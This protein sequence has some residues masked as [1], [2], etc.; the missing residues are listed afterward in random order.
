MLRKIGFTVAA[1]IVALALVAFAP[2]LLRTDTLQYRWAGTIGEGTLTAPIGVAYTGGHL[3][4][5]DAAANRIVVF[6][7]SGSVVADWGDSAIGLARP[8]HISL[9][10]G[11]LLHVAE[12][13]SDRVTILDARGQVVRRVGGF[14]G[15]GVGELDAPGGAVALGDAVV[16]ADFYNH[17]AQA[18]TA[19]GARVIGRPGRVFRG[20]L[21]YPT[22]V[23]ADDSLVYVADAYNHRIQVF[24]SDGEY[25]RRWGGPWG[26][27]GR[28]P[29]KG[30]FNVAIGIEVSG[31]RVYVADFY[32]NRIQIFT[33][34][35]KYLGQVADSLSLPTDAAIG[36]NGDLYVVDFGHKRVVRFARLQGVSP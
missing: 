5:S 13:L 26:L 12:Y 11:G 6:D 4:V 27:G 1:V 18:F 15:S 30:W 31:G 34:R 2:V 22:D 7:T 17:R 20:R 21:H 14:T 33:D 28:G 3:F 9:G 35:G 29:F 36:E 25:V 19:T 23:A 10:T 32:N 16:A 24:R 8:M